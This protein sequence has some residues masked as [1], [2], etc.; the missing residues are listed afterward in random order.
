MLYFITF[1]ILLAIPATRQVLAALTALAFWA[2]ALG[3]C[4]IGIL[5]L[6]TH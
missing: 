1:V 3:A 6:I 5:K 2:L 4:A